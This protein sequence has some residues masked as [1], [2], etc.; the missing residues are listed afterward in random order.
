MGVLSKPC[1]SPSTAAINPPENDNFTTLC[2]MSNGIST[3]LLKIASRCNLDCDYCYVYHSPD[4]SWRRRPK[5]MSERVLRQTIERVY[6][7]VEG[8]NIEKIS[9]VLHGGEPLLAGYDFLHKVFSLFSERIGPK[10]EFGMQ[11]NL[12]LLTPEIVALFSKYHAPIGISLDG[13]RASNDKHRLTH[14]GGSSFDDVMKGI[15]LLR[16][17]VEGRQVFSGILA[18]M[19]LDH[20]P[21]ETYEFF[22]SLEPRGIHFL[23]P[24]ATHENYPPRKTSWEET[25]YADWLIR[26]FDYWWRQDEPIPIRIFDNIVTLRLGGF[27]D[28]ESFG[29]GIVDLLVIETDGAIE[30][31]DTLKIDYE[32]AGDLGLDVF[33]NTIDEAMI[34]PKISMRFHPEAQLSDAC[35]KCEIVKICGGGYLPHRYS[36][37]RLY[38][39]PSVYCTDLKKLIEHIARTTDTALKQMKMTRA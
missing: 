38:S 23:L 20:D 22:R 15:Q 36:N 21:V 3:F 16:S 19:D 18:V 32:G 26:L 9:V 35:T 34:H 37:D 10:V 24:D 25:P 5:L 27:S 17:S 28:D 2:H 11:S 12:T 13:P 8:N 1:S 29:L 30:A 6:E 4:Q 31:V 39:N 14:T 33:N 7:H